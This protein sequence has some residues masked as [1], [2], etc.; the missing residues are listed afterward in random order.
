MSK[1]IEDLKHSHK[2]FEK[3]QLND[4]AAKTPFPLFDTWFQKAIDEKCAEPNAMVL[5]TYGENAPASRIV[6]LK[7][8]LHEQ[9]IFYTN[10][11]SQK[12]REIEQDNRVGVLFFWPQLERQVRIEGTCTKVDNA[13]SDEYFASRPRGSQLGAWASHQSDQAA[14]RDE[15]IERLEQ[16][17]QKFEGQDVPR[18]EHWGGYK[19]TPNYFEFWQGRPSRLHDRVAFKKVDERWEKVRL[20]P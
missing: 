15:I 11:N 14:H 7:E 2:D 1:F 6:Y 8:M 10:Y 9:I 4:V 5:S 19:I 12:G 18:P 17:E 16:Y 13:T 20:N 3:D